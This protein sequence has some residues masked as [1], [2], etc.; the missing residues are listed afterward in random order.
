M[1]QFLHILKKDVR[2]AWPFIIA[3]LVLDCLLLMQARPLTFGSTAVLWP[4]YI[5]LF[6]VTVLFIVQGESLVG[7][8]EFWTTRPYSRWSLAAAKFALLVAALLLPMFLAQV[9]ALALNGFLWPSLISKLLSVHVIWFILIVAPLWAL[10]S[11]TRNLA[12]GLLA[13][14]AG[15]LGVLLAPP[16]IRLVVPQGFHLDPIS[17]LTLFAGSSALTLILQFAFRQTAAA[18][19]VLAVGLVT[20]TILLFRGDR[21]QP[22]PSIEL[23]VELDTTRTPETRLIPIRVGELPIGANSLV[24]SHGTLFQG[25]V[26]PGSDTLPVELVKRNG[27]YWLRLDLIRERHSNE[28]WS[29]YL[30]SIAVNTKR[31][32]QSVLGADKRIESPV[33]AGILK[34]DRTH[35]LWF[36]APPDSRRHLQFALAD[37]AD[38]DKATVLDSGYTP[39]Q[40]W[41]GFGRLALDPFPYLFEFAGQADHLSD[42][43]QQ[44]ENKLL[45]VDELTEVAPVELKGTL[46]IKLSDYAPK[47]R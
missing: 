15:F 18:R 42:E 45:V 9:A 32:G 27:Q 5:L 28:P 1:K 36:E 41:T 13:I 43:L 22:G 44:S 2:R 25:H 4:A 31:L 6:P 24:L 33:H 3:C 8:R 47:I 16:L 37:S 30:A 26:R 12:S 7:D 11:V 35:Y 19:A 23:T 39:M 46:R 10:G 40:H 21:D 34:N 20:A 14:I 29:L 38:P 17:F